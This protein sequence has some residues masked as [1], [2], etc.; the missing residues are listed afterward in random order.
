MTAITDFLHDEAV[1]DAVCDELRLYLPASWT[2]EVGSG[3]NRFFSL[4][5]CECGDLRDFRLTPEETWAKQMP[6]VFAKSVSNSWNTN[7]SGIGGKQAIDY[8]IRVVH[9][10]TDEQARDATTGE[11]TSPY[12]S[13]CQRLKKLNIA[14]FKS[15]TRQLGNPTLTCA[16]SGITAKINVCRYV[17]GYLEGVEDIEMLPGRYY[18]V[19]VDL[20]V[21]TTTA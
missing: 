18:A 4:K 16:D 7:Y 14:L 9:A 13:K 17:G 10:F 15:I 2:S 11:K 21:I 19:A 6:L 8:N 12:R 20:M 5:K 3:G 1:C